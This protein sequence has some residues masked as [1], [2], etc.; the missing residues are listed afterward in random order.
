MKPAKAS[1]GT[2]PCTG[3]NAYAPLQAAVLGIEGR[4]DV[5]GHIADV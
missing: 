5:D 3:V 2:K 1:A 4:G